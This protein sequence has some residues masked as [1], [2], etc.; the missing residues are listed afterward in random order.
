[1]CWTGRLG[2]PGLHFG[3]LVMGGSMGGG[4]WSVVGDELILKRTQSRLKGPS[5]AAPI[6]G[7]FRLVQAPR[8]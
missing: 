3:W 6:Q 8:C 2:W 1:M 5:F 7:P 4:R